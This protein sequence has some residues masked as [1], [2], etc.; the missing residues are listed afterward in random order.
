VQLGVPLLKS[1]N[2][3]IFPFRTA[4]KL[5]GYNFPNFTFPLQFLVM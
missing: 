5:R 4:S 3:N 2:G 1:T